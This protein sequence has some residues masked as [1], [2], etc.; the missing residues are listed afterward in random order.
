LKKL[1][2]MWE[3]DISP[4][5]YQVSPKAGFLDESAGETK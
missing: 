2:D 4:P 1:I 5:L 3:R